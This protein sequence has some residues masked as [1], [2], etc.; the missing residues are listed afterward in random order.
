MEFIEDK[1]NRNQ[2]FWRVDDWRLKDHFESK[3]KTVEVTPV[4]QFFL[5]H[6]EKS[7]KAIQSVY[8]KKYHK[9][10]DGCE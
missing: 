2:Y 6:V 9:K 1:T 3:A 10:C 7:F 4:C 8:V 5:Q